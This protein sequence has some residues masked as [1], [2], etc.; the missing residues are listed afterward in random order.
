MVPEEQRLK[1]LRQHHDSQVAG[2]RGRHRT[3]ALVSRKFI[4]NGLSEDVANY[5][6]GCTKCQKSKADRHS[7]LTKLGP[8]P[9]GEQPCE[10]IGMDFVGELPESEGFNAIGVIT[11]RFTKVQHYLP[12]KTT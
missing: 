8:M 1:V 3:Q 6:A 12:A 2:F 4:L 11:D 7:R 5:V 9:T 10:E